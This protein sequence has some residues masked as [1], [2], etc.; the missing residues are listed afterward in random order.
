MVI[1]FLKR[2]KERE[3]ERMVWYL[4][5]DCDQLLPVLKLS[6]EKL[7]STWKVLM[8]T[9]F[10]V[11]SLELVRTL[12]PSKDD[13]FGWLL[14]LLF[15]SLDI[16]FERKKKKKKMTWRQRNWCNLS[17]VDIRHFLQ[18]FSRFVVPVSNMAIKMATDYV[19]PCLFVSSLICLIR[20][21]SFFSGQRR[22]RSYPASSPKQRELTLE[23][24]NTVRIQT[25]L[26][27]SQILIVRS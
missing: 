25:P 22:S 8:S 26:T 14:L 3:R 5:H 19:I 4:K 27:K 9:I 2:K 21:P 24:E 13:G 20:L 16:H 6:W 7:L 17:S 15:C 11:L 23:K 1:I 10:R 12:F 18:Q